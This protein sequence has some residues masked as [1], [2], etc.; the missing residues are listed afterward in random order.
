MREYRL[1]VR[2]L[3]LAAALSGSL[4]GLGGTP[5]LGAAAST[6]RLPTCGDFQ[7]LR[8]VHGYRETLL[9][10]DGPVLL[11]LVGGERRPEISIARSPTD[12]LGW[13]GQKTPWLVRMTY[14]G[15]LTIT[16]RRIDRPGQVRFALG[17]GQHL[18]KLAYPH[19]DYARPDHGFY[20]LPSTTLFR[21]AG[22]Y[23][24]HLA[25]RSFTERIVVRVV[26]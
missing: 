17:Y 6:T 24:F 11:M 21:S 26:A 14:R 18:R 25:G 7:R 20:G 2:R 3:L 22:C 16:A 15:P 4:V 10:G 9:A 13:R 19:D 23:A 1:G 5:V 12:K 8:Q